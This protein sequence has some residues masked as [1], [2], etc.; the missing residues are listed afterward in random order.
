M[1]LKRNTFIHESM[2]NTLHITDLSM[3][4]DELLTFFDEIN[5]VHDNIKFDYKYSKERIHFLDTTV[6]KIQ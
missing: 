2:V 5:K 6:F 4:K 1:I 3:R